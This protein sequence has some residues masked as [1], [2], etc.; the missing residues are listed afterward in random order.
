MHLFLLLPLLCLLPAMVSGHGRL[1]VPSPRSWPDDAVCSKVEDGICMEDPDAPIN[2]NGDGLPESQRL[3]LQDPN[4]HPDRQSLVCRV[5]NGLQK[6]VPLV[7]LN[8]G[9]TI[10]IKWEF[11]AVSLE[12]SER[13]ETLMGSKA[14]EQSRN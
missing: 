14:L 8:G 4:A 13:K 6:A 5:P 1:T 12:R 3:P 2:V 10:D 11:T 9:G 7:T